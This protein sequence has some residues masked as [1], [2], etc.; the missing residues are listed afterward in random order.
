MPFR[1][2][3]QVGYGGIFGVLAGGVGVVQVIA[4]VRDYEA[5]IVAFDKR[6]PPG[7][8]GFRDAT[9]LVRG[10]EWNFVGTA[11][12]ALGVI[13]ILL[14]IAATLAVVTTLTSR[15]GVATTL[16]AGAI[17]A[18]IY[19]AASAIAISTG[20]HPLVPSSSGVLNSDVPPCFGAF[21]TLL[22]A[23]VWF[24]GRIGVGLGSLIVQRF[25]HY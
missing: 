12:E 1:N 5:Q 17:C 23:L 11:F 19:V 16:I 6:F 2:W 13:A 3:A 7:Y 14:S 9:N 18:G 24:T 22:L 15:T 21:G 20:P 25:P 8:T 10:G 4:V